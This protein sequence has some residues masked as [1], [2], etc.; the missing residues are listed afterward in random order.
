MNEMINKFQ[1]AIREILS[2]MEPEAAQEFVKLF[3]EKLN[4]QKRTQEN[5]GA[6]R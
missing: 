3:N 4:E 1:E 5:P 2:Q 6:S